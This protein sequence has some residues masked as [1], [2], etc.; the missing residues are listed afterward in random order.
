MVRA[1]KLHASP[2]IMEVDEV[3][4]NLPKYRCKGFRVAEVIMHGKASATDP[5]SAS[6]MLQVFQR[7]LWRLAAVRM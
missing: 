2:A 6:R 4:K 1:S 7:D 3:G 5:S